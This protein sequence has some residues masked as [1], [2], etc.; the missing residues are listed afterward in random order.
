[1]NCVQFS[2]IDVDIY[3]HGTA[4]LS[5]LNT[6]ADHEAESCIGDAGFG[7]LPCERDSILTENSQLAFRT[8]MQWDIDSISTSFVEWMNDRDPSLNPISRVGVLTSYKFQNIVSDLLN[9]DLSRNF[10]LLLETA[11]I[12]YS[13]DG[14]T[15]LPNYSHIQLRH[16]QNA[17]GTRVLR[18]LQS[19][20]S[21]SVLVKFSLG[22]LKALFLIL[23]G[24][25]IAIGY[26]DSQSF[27]MGVRSNFP[28]CITK[29]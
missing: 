19:A 14:E 2:L 4:W 20:L 7:E 11:S 29:S 16:I 8:R 12:L 28:K 10:R 3:A 13:H 5:I 15:Q 18:L 6:D 23:I 1:M 9:K 24:T 26:S 21:K 17:A 27:S 22:T 25:I